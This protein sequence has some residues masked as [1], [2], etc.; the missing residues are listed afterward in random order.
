MAKYRIV[1]SPRNNNIWWIEQWKPW[2][3]GGGRWK[4]LECFSCRNPSAVFFEKEI[5]AYIRRS[6]VEDLLDGMEFDIE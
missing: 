6:I 3:L 2:W 5:K 4:T 1:R